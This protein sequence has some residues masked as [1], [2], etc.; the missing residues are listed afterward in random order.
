M[1]KEEKIEQFKVS[2]AKI[3]CAKN[4]FTII[5]NAFDNIYRHLAK[6]KY[7]FC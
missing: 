1:E 3:S 6:E 7:I 2:A 5:L 4:W